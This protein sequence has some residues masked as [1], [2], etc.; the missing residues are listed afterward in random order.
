MA[1]L[2]REREGGL[3]GEEHRGRVMTDTNRGSEEK[4]R[5]ITKGTRGAVVG[6]RRWRWM[7]K[8]N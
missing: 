3:S 5:L 6:G 8:A 7:S 2:E 4:W 1:L